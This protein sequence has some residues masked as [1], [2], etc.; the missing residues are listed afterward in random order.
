M[1][2]PVP[3]EWIISLV[4]GVSIIP[5]EWIISLVDGV[6]IVVLVG[7]CCNWLLVLLVAHNLRDLIT[8]VE[9]IRVLKIMI[10]D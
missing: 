8:T 7:V 4:D 2:E 3:T 10:R 5:T 6:S 9:V 1:N